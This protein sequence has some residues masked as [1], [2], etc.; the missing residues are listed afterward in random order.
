MSSP[1]LFYNRQDKCKDICNGYITL[2]TR[3]NKCWCRKQ[4]QH[5]Y[6]E[7]FVPDCSWKVFK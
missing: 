5:M 3:G 6:D 2:K 4:W 1:W 7:M